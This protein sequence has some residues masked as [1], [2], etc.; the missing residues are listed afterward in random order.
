[1]TEKISIL[2]DA[3]VRIDGQYASVKDMLTGSDASRA[4]QRYHLIG[5][6]LRK[7]HRGVTRKIADGR[8]ADDIQ[9]QIGQEPIR[10]APRALEGET[11]IRRKSNRGDSRFSKTASGLAIAAS[12]AAVTFFGLNLQ[13]AQNTPDIPAVTEKAPLQTPVLAGNTQWQTE[14][15]ESENDLNAFLVEHGEFTSPS[16]LNGL[17]AYAKFVSYDTRR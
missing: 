2:V 14:Q 12:L 3:E 7:R 15:P 8:L 6:V 13:Q 17:I 1:M 10:I 5:D 4:W 9:D 11:L 16:G